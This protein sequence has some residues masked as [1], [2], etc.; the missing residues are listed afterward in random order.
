VQDAIVIRCQNGVVAWGRQVTSRSGYRWICGR[1]GFTVTQPTSLA[2]TERVLLSIAQ[3]SQQLAG[4][5]LQVIQ[6]RV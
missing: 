3:H 4:T 1:D 5:I 2:D 6:L